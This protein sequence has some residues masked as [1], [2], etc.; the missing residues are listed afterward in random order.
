MK[1]INY[2]TLL[3]FLIGLNFHSAAQLSCSLSSS[4][5]EIC[6]GESVNI[7]V[8]G[9]TPSPGGCS[10]AN[11]PANLQQGL[12][13]WYPF[14]GNANDESGNGNNGIVSGAELTTDRFGNIQGAYRFNGSSDFIQILDSPELN[15]SNQYSMSVWVKIPDYSVNAG[16]E[17]ARTI[18]SK[19]RSAGGT[20]YAFRSI[21]GFSF[22]GQNPLTYTSGWNNNIIN[23]TIGGNQDV[24]ALNTWCHL[25]FTFD[26]SFVRLYKNGQLVNSRATSF[27]LNSAQTSLF[28]GKEFEFSNQFSRW[29][30]GD[31]DD[32]ALY[33]RSLSAEDILELY[34][35]E[36]LSILWSN[37][38][39][40]SNIIESPN[41]TTTYSVTVTKGNQTCTSEITIAVNQASAAT[42]NATITEGES[43]SFNG[44]N[45][46][47]AGTY[48]AT[49][50]N[51]AGCDSVVTLNLTVNAAP[52]NC[53]VAVSDTEI[54]AGET[55]SISVGGFTPSPGGCSSANMPANLQQGLVAWY[56]F[57]GNAEDESPNDY[58]GT[59]RNAVLTS[60][61]FGNAN[62]AFSFTTGQDIIVNGTQSLNLYPMSISLWYNVDTIV[63]I[64]DEANIFSKYSPA[65]WNGYAIITSNMAPEEGN[66]YYPTVKPWYTRS[67]NNRIIGRYGSAPFEH[68]NIDLDAWHHMVFTVA[69]DGGK[70]YVNGQLIATDTWDGTAG[71]SS[72][73]FIWKIGGLYDYW[74]NGKID[75]IA[76]YNRVLTAAEATQLYQYQA[77]SETTSIIWSTGETTAQISVSPTET[78][79]YNVTVN[80][81]DQTCTSEVTITVNQAS[82]ATVNATITEGETYSFNG[83]SLITAG[84][85]TATQQNAAGCDS[86][87]TLNL[88][89]NPFVDGINCTISTSDTELCSGENVTLTMEVSG[90]SPAQVLST[91]EYNV[92]GSY[93]GKTYLVTNNAMTWFEA[94]TFAENLPYEGATLAVFETLEENNAVDGLTNQYNEWLW[95][96]LFQDIG[97]SDYAE[98]FGGWS[99]VN[100]AELTYSNWEAGEPNNIGGENFAHLKRYPNGKWNDHYAE[101]QSK[102]I[103]EINAIQSSSYLWNNGETTQSINVSPATTSTFSCTYTSGNQTCTSEVTIT[104]NQ[105]SAASV[106]AS[107][108]EGETYSF[109]G[110]SLTTAGTYTATL[111]NAAGCDSV[112][113]LNLTVN[114]A[115]SGCFA[116][117]FSN[118]VQGTMANGLTVSAV[119]SNAA[120]ALNQPE[121]VVDGVVNFVSLGFGGSIT[122]AFEAP[123]A[124]G[125]GADIRIDEATWGN[126]PCNRYPERADVFASQDG[127]NFV[128]LGQ[129]C[130]DATLDLGVLSW[131]QYIRIVDASDLLSFSADADGYDVN[132]VECLNGTATVTGNDGLV[133]CSLQEIVSYNPGMRK[134]GTPVTSSRSDAAKALGAPQNNNTIN[135][136]AL[137]FGGTLVAKFD[138]VVFNQ[139]G[140]DLRVTETSFGNPSC[141]NY[142]EKARISLSLDN[143]SW[144]EVGELCQDGEVDLGS[145]P[146][147][148]YI[149][150]QDASPMSSNRFNGAADGYDVDAVVVLNNG[151]G[152]TARFAEET[153]VEE[154][155]DFNVYPNPIEDYA[156]ISLSD[157]DRET[158]FDLLL[159]DAAGRIVMKQPIVMNNEGYTLFVNDL[160]RGIYTLTLSNGEQLFVKRLV[161]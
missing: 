18:I 83:Q 140:N 158:E 11:M 48:T 33:N 9:F 71:P 161:K 17:R 98:P 84:T 99:W 13:A 23:S 63:S 136:V 118:F 119:R 86:M 82:A 43:Y 104:V 42:V 5:A 20:G 111:Q 93:N 133:G 108:T 139:A 125:A 28:I 94:K 157:L 72:S 52:Q 58:N 66:V 142:P 96:G 47:T 147:A 138:Y 87:V 8:G 92:V 123:I 49:L 38:A 80:S 27:V 143:V 31:L 65:A 128:Y 22:D 121:T 62:Q 145:M 74:Y 155:M 25:V 34:N 7:S 3:V 46:S 64:Y 160:A 15:F 102:A 14:C 59:V 53:D 81:G 54:C 97:S 60:D 100:G 57:C 127:S 56:P 137:G 51:A 24:L 36:N 120:Q 67:I 73:S 39:T 69:P 152:A 89:V 91:S 37:G 10:S 78:T 1:K 4:A 113:T 150:I 41:Q 105:P 135:F 90:Q 35:S 114:P 131:A 107:I 29:F 122:L 12:V 95:F 141:T 77:Q 76:V 6:A 159:V 19:P 110:Q 68:E 40:S 44:Q 30:K 79:T 115:P 75:D 134:N 148:Q 132:G 101:V 117:S 129:V 144:A 61:R 32:V 2:V 16:S 106:N 112:V 103:I 55:V 109:N 88:T 153:A 26:G 149:K 151:C 124:N 21:E 154:T 130:Q 156:I 45:L 116:S 126:N 85:Y 146:Y 50:Q 70:C